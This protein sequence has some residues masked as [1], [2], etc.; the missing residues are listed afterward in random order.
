MPSIIS[1]LYT[2]TMSTRCCLECGKG[3][4]SLSG[5]S[6]HMYKCPVV[7]GK[8]TNVV[9]NIP[10]KSSRYS[11]KSDSNEQT[12]S[13]WIGLNKVTA[14]TDSIDNSEWIDLNEETIPSSKSIHRIPSRLSTTTS[15]RIDLYEEVTGKKAG[16]IF[17]DSDIFSCDGRSSGRSGG[18]SSGRSGGSSGGRSGG[19]SNGRSDCRSESLRRSPEHSSRYHPFQSETD[20]ALAQ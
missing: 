18:K 16:Q 3:I 2:S 6:R 19:R 11:I 20:F 5:L 8:K 4:K 7:T 9:K 17:D 12:D 1:H 14:Q 15:I 13:N 10:P